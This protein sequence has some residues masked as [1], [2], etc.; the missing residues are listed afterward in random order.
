M[1]LVIDA[2]AATLH[3]R[4]E[5]CGGEFANR[6]LDPADGHIAVSHQDVA[7]ICPACTER[8]ATKTPCPACRKVHGTSSEHFPFDHMTDYDTGEV[9]H[10]DSMVGYVFPDTGGVVVEDSRYG[11]GN[12]MRQLQA[13]LILAMQRHPHVVAARAKAQ[14][15]QQR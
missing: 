9:Q 15:A 12:P 11:A 3:H 10:P 2:T 4:C 14:A 13:K 7:V 8:A 1:L 5:H 6:S